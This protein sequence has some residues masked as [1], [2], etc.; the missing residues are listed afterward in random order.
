MLSSFGRSNAPEIIYNIGTP[1]FIRKEI[2]CG[3]KQNSR[4]TLY[5][6]CDNYFSFYFAFI[7]KKQNMLNGLISPELFYE[8][9]LTKQNLNT[10]IG[11][12][13]EGIC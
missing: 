13:F 11:H 5:S 10:F 9:E 8:K 7:F 3:E 12:R 6:I 2:P 1:V 4:N